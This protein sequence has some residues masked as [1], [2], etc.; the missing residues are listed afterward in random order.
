MTEE[1]KLIELAQYGDVQAQNDLGIYYLKKFKNHLGEVIDRAAGENA[2]DWFSKAAYEGYAEAQYNLAWMYDE[3][4]GFQ[5]DINEKSKLLDKSASQ[6]YPIAK[7]YRTKVQPVF[8]DVIA[9]PN[10]PNENFFKAM[11]YAN[12]NQEHSR[13]K[14]LFFYRQLSA[15][16][17]LID[18][19][20][21]LYSPYIE[22]A[23]RGEI[24]AQLDL[25]LIYLNGD[26][27]DIDYEQ[28][29]FWFNKAAQQ[30]D[31]W[32]QKNLGLMYFSGKYGSQTTTNTKTNK[33]GGSSYE[34]VI[35]YDYEKA[36]DWFH[37]AAI[38]GHDWS[39]FMTGKMYLD[40]QG[41]EKNFTEGLNWIEKV[42]DK[43]DAASDIW[44]FP[45]MYE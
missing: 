28:A 23:E 33:D 6:N 34:I 22:A 40:G 20:P 32:S 16:G 41:V 12:D 25:G 8:Q 27:V 31:A 44:E 13:F 19:S 10:I 39:Q 2:M 21:P 7:Y 5:K 38:Q 37:M 9:P 36:F 24:W 17:S 43:F 3:A 26:N 30:G 1:E 35:N 45:E 18:Y 42:K 15:Q 29:F 4:I 14:E 11:N